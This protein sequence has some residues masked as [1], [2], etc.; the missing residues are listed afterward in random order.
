[1]FTRQHQAVVGNTGDRVLPVY[2]VEH[3]GNNAI[4]QTSRSI[5]VGFGANITQRRPCYV[6]SGKL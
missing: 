4:L 3:T 5:Y 6:T 1:M 2:E